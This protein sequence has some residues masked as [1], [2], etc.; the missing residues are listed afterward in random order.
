MVVIDIK[1]ADVTKQQLTYCISTSEEKS[2]WYYKV[3]CDKAKAHL[4]PHYLNPKTQFILSSRQVF[5][6]MLMGPVEQAKVSKKT[7]K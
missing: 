3:D 5:Q 6:A 4:M 7:K 2:E 1:W